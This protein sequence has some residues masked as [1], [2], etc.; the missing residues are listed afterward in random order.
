MEKTTISEK[1]PSTWYVTSQYEYNT[2]HRLSRK[3]PSSRR[4]TSKNVCVLRMRLKT[5]KL[6]QIKLFHK[7]T[8]SLFY[9]IESG[10]GIVLT[11]HSTG[12]CRLK[13]IA[14]LTTGSYFGD[15]MTA[16]PSRSPLLQ[17]GMF[18]A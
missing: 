13:T 14:T 1:G 12:T 9:I 16:R 18:R 15:S 2:P 4:S 8:C 3:I 5:L 10:G 11:E 17:S 7:V 6:L